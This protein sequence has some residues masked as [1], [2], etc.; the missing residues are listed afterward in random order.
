MVKNFFIQTS[1]FFGLELR[2]SPCKEVNTPINATWTLLFYV[3]GLKSGASGMVAP[4]VD[5]QPA[6]AIRKWETST[7]SQ[8]GRLRHFLNLP[9]QF[10]SGRLQ[11]HRNRDGYATF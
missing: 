5:L 2:M 4:F 6:A 3:A 8:P 7:A 9:L 10:G 1:P 11:Q